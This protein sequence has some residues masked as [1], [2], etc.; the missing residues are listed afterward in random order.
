MREHLL[1]AL[2]M[3][4]YSKPQWENIIAKKPISITCYKMKTSSLYMLSL[5]SI[6]FHPTWSDSTAK[7]IEPKTVEGTGAL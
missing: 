5:S 6:I 1:K 3:L 7:N 2:V 4:S